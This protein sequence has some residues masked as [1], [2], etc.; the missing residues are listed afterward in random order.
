[1]LRYVPPHY[2]EGCF[3]LSLLKLFIMHVYIVTESSCAMVGIEKVKIV[4]VSSQQQAA[5]LKK[6]AGCILVAGSS[7]SEVLAKFCL[8]TSS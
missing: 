5:F 6:Y 2:P 1:M 7:V 8:P 3:L 4:Q